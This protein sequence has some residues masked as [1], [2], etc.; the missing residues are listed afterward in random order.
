M[1]DVNEMRELHDWCEAV[2]TPAPSRLAKALGRLDAAIARE[3]DQ[4]RP[5]APGHRGIP[6]WVVPLASAAAVTAT[7]A[8]TF[9]VV[10]AVR[11]T[12]TGV[13][14]Q[15]APT[16]LATVTS[17]LT[18]TLGQSYHFTEHDGGYYIRNGQ[19]TARSHGTCTTNA[20]PVRHL[21]A[22]SCSTGTAYRKIGSYTYIYIP[23]PADHPGKHWERIPTACKVSVPIGK[24]RSYPSVFNGFTFATPQQMLSEIKQAA[25]VTVAGPASGPGWTGTRYVFSG[26]TLLPVR[27]S[28]TVDVDQ[29]G[30]AR[31]L[32]LTI[33]LRSAV[34][35]FVMTQVLTFSDFGAPVTVTPPPADQTFPGRP[36]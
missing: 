30:R 21:Q 23:D 2:P 24:P 18:R 20:D 10:N 6:G 29:Q 3:A 25:K 15:A 7:I 4:R 36:C 35:V 5:V 8:G 17:A 32:A 11:S 31:S 27:I 14:Q 16:A 13:A 22:Y 12:S 33:R 9:A 26:K 1:K 19:I 34:N 28:G